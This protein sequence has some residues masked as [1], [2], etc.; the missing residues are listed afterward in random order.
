[1]ASSNH[2][3]TRPTAYRGTDSRVSLTMDHVLEEY[4]LWAESLDAWH[5]FSD[6]GSD[7]G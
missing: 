7:I 5:H 3:G 4:F 6:T 2:R 1:M